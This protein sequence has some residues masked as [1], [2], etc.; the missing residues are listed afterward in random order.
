MTKISVAVATFNEEKNIGK[1]L[2][3]AADWVDEIVVVDGSSEDKTVEIANKF[4]SKVIVTDNPPIFHINKQKAMDASTGDWILQLDAD[5]VVSGELKDE[6]LATIKH[7]TCL[8]G[9]QALNNK[10]EE[11][12]GYWVP[13][14]NFFLGKFLTKGGQ[15]PDYSL[16]LYKRGKGRLPCRNVHEQAEVEGPTGY[17]KNP[18]LHYPYSD[19]SEYLEHF[20]RYTD[21]FAKEYGEKR[22]GITPVSIISYLLF[23]PLHWFLKTY[24][25][26]KGFMDGIP[27]LVFSL[28][29]SLRFPVSYIKYLNN[30]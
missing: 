24:F 22:L 28:F 19:F 20:S 27:G 5:E 16:R 10:Q 6:I 18:L 7:K 17:L 4:T 29:S 12:N 14:K 1:C 9:R 11:I 30:K 21:I 3:S 8:A 13:R 26:H 15:Y 2:E 25:R 23:K